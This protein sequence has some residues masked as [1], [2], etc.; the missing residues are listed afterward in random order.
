[1]YRV[2]IQILYI[3]GHFE[4]YTIWYHAYW[5][6]NTHTEL[7]LPV[8]PIIRIFWNPF[9]SIEQFPNRNSESKSILEMLTRNPYSKFWLEILTRNADLK[10]LLEMLTRNS[11]SK[12][13]LEILTRNA[14][15]K[16]LLE[17]LTR[18]PY[19]KCRLEISTRNPDTKSWL[20]QLEIVACHLLVNLEN[21]SPLVVK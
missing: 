5:R 12:C 1:M 17:M 7:G 14:D 19:S 8:V 15:S 21:F 10:S 6:L 9:V 11:Y 4:D 16:S 20:L 13:W 3:H 18:N 2:S